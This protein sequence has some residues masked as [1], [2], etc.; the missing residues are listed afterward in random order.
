MP[1]MRVGCVW[2]RNADCDLLISIDLAVWLVSAHSMILGLLM[3]YALGNCQ[4][5]TRNDELVGWVRQQY[6]LFALPM[7][8]IS[9]GVLCISLA[10]VP[11]SPRTRMCAACVV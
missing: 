7:T 10:C 5:L 2:L 4:L 6:R 8:C 11:P 1:R 3:S 9:V